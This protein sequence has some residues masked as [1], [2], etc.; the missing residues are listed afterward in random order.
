MLHTV[1]HP[2]YR[3]QSA[4]YNFVGGITAD[5]GGDAPEDIMGGLKV[6]LNSLSWRS[7]GSRVSLCMN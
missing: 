1:L 4:F 2:P 7:G 5:G 6:A 3:D